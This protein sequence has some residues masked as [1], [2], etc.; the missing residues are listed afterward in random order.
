MV[1]CVTIESL[2]AHLSNLAPT[3]TEIVVS[4][5][6]NLLEQAGVS[7]DAEKKSEE[8]DNITNEMLKMVEDAAA[9][10]PGTKIVLVEP[11]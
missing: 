9:K 1:R 10:N 11:I 4:V 3:Q 5:L 7:D 8:L 2:D 6:D